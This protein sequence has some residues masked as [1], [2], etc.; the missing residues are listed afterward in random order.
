VHEFCAV[1]V[2]KVEIGAHR[3]LHLEHLADGDVLVT[4]YGTRGQ[5]DVDVQSLADRRTMPLER[6]DRPKRLER[7]VVSPQPQRLELRRCQRR[8]RFVALEQR[9]DRRG[10]VKLLVFAFVQPARSFRI[11]RATRCQFVAAKELVAEEKLEAR[12]QSGC[13]QTA[14]TRSFATRTAAR[15]NTGQS[16]RTVG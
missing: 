16:R 8:L 5:L 9:R 4:Q 3:V 13:Q 12:A 2:V 6:S 15:M 11:P 1:S 7:F 10:Q 14:K